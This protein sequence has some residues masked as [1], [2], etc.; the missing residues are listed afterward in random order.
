MRVSSSTG[1]AVALLALTAGCSSDRP[2]EARPVE[3]AALVAAEAR[4]A[5]VQLACDGSALPSCPSGQTGPSCA[6]ACD[7]EGGE[8]A[9]DGSSG[10]GS[11]VDFPDCG[12]RLY[13]HSDGT[14]YGMAAERSHIYLRDPASSEARHLYALRQHAQTWPSDFGLSPGVTAADLELVA[15][16][17]FRTE[18]GGLTLVKFVQSYRGLPLWGSERFVTL[19][20]D[21]EGLVRVSGALVD[22]RESY[23]FSEKSASESVARSA[24]LAAV[25]SNTSLTNAQ[26]INPTLVAIPRLQTLAWQASVHDGDGLF[27]YNIVVDANPDM[28]PSLLL[29]GDMGVAG[30]TNTSQIDVRSVP[31]DSPDFKDPGWS[32]QQVSGDSQANPL[33]G[34]TDDFT[35]ETQLANP[36]VV[37]IDFGGF[38]STGDLVTQGNR[39]LSPSGTFNATNGLDLQAQVFFQL[40][41]EWFTYTDEALTTNVLGVQSRRWDSLLG[42]SVFP[43]EVSAVPAGQY[44]PRASIDLDRTDLGATARVTY[45]GA[46]PNSMVELAFPELVHY[47]AGPGAMHEPI[48]SIAFSQT[49]T[50]VQT[51]AHEFGHFVDLFLGPGFASWTLPPCGAGG[52]TASCVAGTSDEAPPLNESIAQIFSMFYLARTFDVA[53]FGYCEMITGLSSPPGFDPGPC[54]P[55]NGESNFFLRDEVC[56]VGVRCDRPT[57]EGSNVD[58]SGMFVPTG[59]CSDT[60]GYRTYSLF[61]AFWALIH[62]F[63]CDPNPPFACQTVAWG[64]NDPSGPLFDALLYALELS[65][66]SYDELLED[67]LTHVACNAGSVAYSEVNALLCAH[68]ARDCAAPMPVACETCG[69]GVR[70]GGETCDGNDWVA[71]DCASIPGFVG[72]TLTCDSMCNLDVSACVPDSAGSSSGAAADVSTS[73]GGDGGDD[74]SSGTATGTDGAPGGSSGND[75]CACSSGGKNGHGFLL[76]A[77][78]CGFALARRRQA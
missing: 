54:M 28:T 33:L 40:V 26:I 57:D 5:G 60:E 20:F 23:A 46:N 63:S 34:S 61:Q 19:G 4:I 78:V 72:G 12:F 9:A 18:T 11:S 65:P 10:G 31:P 56:P 41:N 25:A 69:N 37:T 13:C 38:P 74:T 62:G 30:L 44:R 59:A 36:D 17:D 70:E 2:L 35:M 3:D 42:S 67:I 39:F 51:I 77:L 14:G 75:G 8:A 76:L 29:L 58:S 6:W 48:G 73:A 53:D 64:N 55:S 22:S 7:P 15:A 66:A 32:F 21:D 71:P 24:M 52:C 49:A 45:G 43:M 16:P 1:F 68:G 47:A 50:D 27:R